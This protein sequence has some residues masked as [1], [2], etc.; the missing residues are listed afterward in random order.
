MMVLLERVGEMCGSARQLYLQELKRLISV[1]AA[2]G[3]KTFQSGVLAA[4]VR[5]G[6]RHFGGD[7]L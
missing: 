4:Y 1:L 5:A 6:F 7:A 3:R 2:T